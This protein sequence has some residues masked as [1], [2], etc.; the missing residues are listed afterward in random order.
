MVYK[1]SKR[2]KR[3]LSCSRYPDCKGIQNVDREG[4]PV[5]LEM[6]EFMCP[7][8]GKPM[9]KRVGRFGPFLGC[10]GYPECK[11]IQNIDKKTGQ[12]LPPKPPPVDT[13]LLCPKCGK[14]NIVIRQGK[15]G[16]FMSCSGFPKCRTTLPA[17]RL[18]EFKTAL[19]S[20]KSWPDDVKAKF[21]TKKPTE[22]EAVAEAPPPSLPKGKTK[23]PAKPRKPRATKKVTPPIY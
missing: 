1:L 14:K 8:C 13:G 10:S 19:A 3:F 5:Q 15:R 4:K 21:G 2:G 7:T 11:I 22:G 6:T 20:G 12:P 17:E 18:E 16:P 9:I 23:A